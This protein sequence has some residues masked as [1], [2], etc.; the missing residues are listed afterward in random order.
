MHGVENIYFYHIENTCF[1]FEVTKHASSIIYKNLYSI[2][3]V[4]YT[5]APLLFSLGFN[6]SLYINFH[7]FLMLLM[8]K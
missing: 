1:V 7:L 3:H 4:I 6:L 8:K 5:R 2:L